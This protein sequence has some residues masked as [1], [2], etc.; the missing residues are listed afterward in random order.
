LNEKFLQNIIILGVL[1]I[2]QINPENLLTIVSNLSLSQIIILM[3]TGSIMVGKVKFEG[4]KQKMPIYIV[5]CPKH[6][7]HLT[8]PQGHMANLVCPKCALEQ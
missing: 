7:F 3:I 6:G 5:K 2:V 8:Y 1:G 4:W